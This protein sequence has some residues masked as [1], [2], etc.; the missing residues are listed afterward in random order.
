M[1]FF[2]REKETYQLAVNMEKLCLYLMH[3]LCWILM[4]FLKTLKKTLDILE[5]Y[6]INQNYS[7]CRLDKKTENEERKQDFKDFFY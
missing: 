6:Y 7:Y 3:S 1:L 2:S 4:N 5:D